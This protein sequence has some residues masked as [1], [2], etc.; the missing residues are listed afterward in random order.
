MSEPSPSAQRGQRAAVLR[1]PVFLGHETGAHVENPGRLLAIDAEL[2]RRGLLGNR[3]EVSFAP[4]AREA[5]ARVHD[6]RYL[7]LLEQ[8]TVAGGAW[9]D[10][11]TMI[12]PDSLEVAKLAAGAGIAA[13]D[14]ALDDRVKRAFVL[15]RPPGHHAT[16]QRGMGF[17]LIN[18]IAAAAAHAISR[19]VN[20]VAIVDWDVHHGNGTQDIFY[21]N[22]QVLFC[23]VHQSPLYP[24]TGD[25][26]EKGIGPGWGFTLNIPL[27]P[28]EGDSTYLRVFDEIILPC[29]RK[30]SPELVLISAG[31]D[32]HQSDPLGSMRVT[33]AGFRAM[34]ERTI[35]LAEETA[36]GRVVAF[37]EGGYDPQAL[38]RSVADVIDALDSDSN[39]EYDGSDIQHV[40]EETSARP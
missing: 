26:S 36:N 15:G 20:R 3:P 37:L 10:A 24:G 5:I 27:P 19:G 17:C 30:Y 9:L 38:G 16:R 29:V 31:F 7:D 14:A 4:A 11:D 2:E 34:A 22:D 18:N 12:G 28:G 8:V 39:G 40:N 6:E 23:S 1:S 21:G 32:A 25:V 33:D 35:E 13:V